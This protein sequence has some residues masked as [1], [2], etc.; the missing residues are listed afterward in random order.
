MGA[1][2][3]GENRSLA[4]PDVG[5]KELQEIQLEHIGS[6]EEVDVL[7]FAILKDVPCFIYLGSVPQM[8]RQTK[9]ENTDN[10]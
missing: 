9:A 1:T 10:I 8:S 2:L 3:A 7:S 5:E 4:S 6:S